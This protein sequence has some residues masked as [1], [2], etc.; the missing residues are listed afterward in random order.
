[1]TP[2]TWGEGCNFL[3]SCSFLPIFSAIDAPR[4]GLHLPFGHHKQWGPPAKMAS[5]PYLKSS[6][7]GCPTLVHNERWSQSE[8]R[9]PVNHERWMISGG[10][11]V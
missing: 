11:T 3:A 2:P 6:L 5:K 7:V 9:T 1:M 8:A 10:K 4:G